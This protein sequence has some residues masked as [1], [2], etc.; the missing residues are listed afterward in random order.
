MSLEDLR[1]IGSS[2]ITSSNAI[3]KL[4]GTK[5]EALKFFESRVVGEIETKVNPAGKPEAQEFQWGTAGSMMQQTPDGPKNIIPALRY[6]NSNP[7]GM[8]FIKFD[9]I[10]VE[11]GTTYLIDAKRNIPYW[12]PEAMEGYKNTFDRINEAKKQN[13]EIKIIY[14]FPDKKAKTKFTDWLD[15]NPLY[16][17]TIDEIRI[18]PE[19]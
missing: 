15:K 4:K 11:N 2:E 6:D 13:P 3:K 1:K 10:R 19:K 7:R 14:E 9:G 17:K 12:I 16:Q 8:N 18:R 5:E